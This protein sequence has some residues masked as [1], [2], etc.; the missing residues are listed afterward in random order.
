MID[1]DGRLVVTV[2]EKVEQSP[3]SS[4][5]RSP[6]PDGGYTRALALREGEAALPNRL[7]AVPLSTRLEPN[8]NGWIRRRKC[9][10]GA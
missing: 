3:P 7:I 6:L 10:A 5:R 1:R 2:P 9:D 4:H 8:K